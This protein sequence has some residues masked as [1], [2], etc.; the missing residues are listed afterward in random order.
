MQAFEAVN[1]EAKERGLEIVRSEIVGLIPEAAAFDG[2][3]ERLKLDK[4]P[5]ILEERMRG[6]GLLT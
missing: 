5:G 6:A 2:M 3:V 1:R 4:S